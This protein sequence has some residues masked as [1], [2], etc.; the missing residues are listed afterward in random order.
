[1]PI[2]QDVFHPIRRP[3]A[4]ER[5]VSARHTLPVNG[6]NLD[7]MTF[8]NPQHPPVVFIHGFGANPFVY[9]RSLVALARKDLYVIAPALPSFGRSSPLPLRR[10]NVQGV[11]EHLAAFL[12]DHYPQH[13]EFALVGHSFGGGVALRIAAQYPHLA[14]SLT[15]ICPVGGAGQGH[16]S[17]PTM[18]IGLLRGDAGAGW[19]RNG[20]QHFLPALIRHTAGVLASGLSA[21]SS[22][23]VEDVYA[24]DRNGIPV[25]VFFAHQDRLVRPGLIPTLS[26]PTLLIDTQ[27][28]RHSWLIGEPERFVDL[29]MSAWE[30]PTVSPLE[31]EAHTA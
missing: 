17:V 18:A 24:V 12:T 31:G 7:V 25:R 27:P 16:A 5:V 28:G 3:A 2:E 11:A 29:V 4:T 20:V 19:L 14:K 8:G 6:R 21:W 9:L 22:D 23:Q 10:Q 26:S 30:A 15:L 1:V 13:H